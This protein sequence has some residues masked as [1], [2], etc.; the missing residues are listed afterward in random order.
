MVRCRPTGG[1]DAAY[2]YLPKSVAH[3]PAPDA[4]AARLRAA[5]FGDVS[6]TPLTLGIAAI[7]VGV[8]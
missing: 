3:F 2:A 8:K 4:L 6:W 7:H 1:P 5:G